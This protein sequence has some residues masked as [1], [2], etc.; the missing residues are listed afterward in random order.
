MGLMPSLW[1]E[2]FYHSHFLPSSL[3][4]GLQGH[5]FS[6]PQIWHHRNPV[7]PFKKMEKLEMSSNSI[8]WHSK[9]NAVWISFQ[10]CTHLGRIWI[11]HSTNVTESYW[12]GTNFCTEDNSTEQYKFP[13]LRDSVV[14]CESQSS[15]QSP[16]CNDNPFG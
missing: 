11:K 10:E 13:A 9:V 14:W 16:T 12:T 8:R 7:S 5:F 4:I 2:S 15:S 3:L 1:K 6:S